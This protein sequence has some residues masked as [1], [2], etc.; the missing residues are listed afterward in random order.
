MGSNVLT[1]FNAVYFLPYKGINFC[2]GEEISGVTTHEQVNHTSNPLLF[3]LG[4]DPG[5]KYPIG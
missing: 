1:Y 5:E 4:R 2:P 3:H